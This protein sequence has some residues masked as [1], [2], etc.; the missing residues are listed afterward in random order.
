MWFKIQVDITLKPQ[1]G[2]LK[3]TDIIKGKMELDK[4]S[5]TNLNL[6]IAKSSDADLFNQIASNDME[7][8]DFQ[9]LDLQLVYID[10]S[11][12]EYL[13]EQSIRPQLSVS[14]NFYLNDS[15]K[16]KIVESFTSRTQLKYA[17]VP[18]IKEVV[19]LK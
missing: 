17:H 2:G 7:F 5:L 3:I 13:I 9:E 12:Q 4:A 19:R 10:R 11:M 18:S 16:K 6:G 15:I 14:E 1:T 8:F